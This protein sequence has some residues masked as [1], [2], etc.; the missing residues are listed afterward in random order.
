MTKVKKIVAAAVAALAIGTIGT[1]AYASTYKLPQ[2]DHY[3]KFKFTGL[4]GT[5]YTEEVEKKNSSANDAKVQ[6]TGGYVSDSSSISVDVSYYKLN[7]TTRVIATE[8]KKITSPVDS[9]SLKYNIPRGEG[10][11]NLLVGCGSYYAAEVS[12][13]WEP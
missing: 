6:A 7:S 8:S 11:A 4:G 1:G 10:S 2:Y 13:T 12:G 3:F 9:V 5:Q